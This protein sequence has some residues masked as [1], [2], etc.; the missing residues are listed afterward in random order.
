MQEGRD[1]KG[2]ALWVCRRFT[3]LLY[4]NE[5]VTFENKTKMYKDDWQ[6]YM[7]AGKKEANEQMNAIMQWTTPPLPS[8][9]SHL[10]RL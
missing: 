2:L 10:C 7:M 4:A 3:D 1:D 6:G 8:S 9:Q 5:A